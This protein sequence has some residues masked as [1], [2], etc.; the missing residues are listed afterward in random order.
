MFCKALTSQCKKQGPGLYSSMY[1]F[2]GH[3]T[4]ATRGYGTQEVLGA[5]GII[6]V[7]EKLNEAKGKLGKKRFHEYSSVS[8]LYIMLGCKTW[9]PL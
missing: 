2:F 3:V 1:M 6:W 9:T 7:L 4:C 8:A 5:K